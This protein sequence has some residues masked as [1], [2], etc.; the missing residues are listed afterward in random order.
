MK[1]YLFIAVGIA[2]FILSCDEKDIPD[3][4]PKSEE[5]VVAKDTVKHDIMMKV[6]TS[7]SYDYNEIELYDSSTHIL[8]FKT[9]HP[10]FDK[11]TNQPFAFFVD[12]DSI[13]KGEF[14]PIYFSSH[15]SLPYI[16]TYPLHYQNYALEIE[17]RENKPDP[18]H[19]PR[20]IQALK[21]RGLLH[22]GLLIKINSLETNGSQITFS[23]DITNKDNS[24]L[25]IF[26]PDK[27]GPNL[28]HY[29]T[30]GLIFRRLPWSA[31]TTVKY[32]SLTPSPWN[33]W[34]ID[35]LSN[36]NPGE[37][38]TFV[39]SYPISSPLGPGEYNVSFEY[40]GLSFQVKREEL[41]QTTGR[42]WLGD[43]RVSKNFV[44]N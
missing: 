32:P 23:F 29:F 42:I 28:F 35:W 4:E 9:Y 6:G 19:H 31:S 10:E 25:L 37:K 5:I 13:Y 1:N 18:R 34:K 22:S 43:L 30:N 27:M 12:G 39:I 2:F 8:Y 14:W 15:S 7:L 20:F 16:A 40:P 26:D 17:I 21:D 11:L 38:K 41:N 44:I 36:I 3:P 33:S 24:E